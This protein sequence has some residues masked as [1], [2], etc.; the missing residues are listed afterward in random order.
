MVHDLQGVFQ[1]CLTD[2]KDSL[3][4]EFVD[5]YLEVKRSG[6][7][8][9]PAGGV[10]VGAVAG[11]VVATELAGVSDGHATQVGAHSENDE[12]LCVLD[13]LL[14]S[15]GVP[16]GGGVHGTALGDFL[17]GSVPDEEGLASPLEGHVL[18]LRDISQL[19]LDRG[20]SQHI[21]RRGPGGD[22]LVD[23]GLGGVGAEDAQTSGQ[24]VAEPLS[25][26][27]GVLVVAGGVLGSATPVVREVRDI[28]VSSVV[29]TD[30]GSGPKS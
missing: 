4:K 30:L 19:D 15:L 29:A 23:H 2:Q 5:W 26:F 16:Q 1:H 13:S 20:Q 3:G 21:L 11:T 22:E 10:V 24:H 25:G 18:A 27:S 9:D 28:N 6:S 8:P 12:P 14:V 7:L 17:C